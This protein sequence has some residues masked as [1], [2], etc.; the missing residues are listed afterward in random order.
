MAADPLDVLVVDD[1]PGDVALIEQ[2]IAEA[3]TPTTFEAVRDGQQALNRIHQRGDF[4]STDHPDLILLD[5]NLPGTNGETVLKEIREHPSLRH[6]PVMVL[7][8]SRNEQ[9]VKQSYRLGANGYFPKPVDPDE[10]QHM[11]ESIIDLCGNYAW[12]PPVDP[13]E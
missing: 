3:P 12:L 4:E 9:T 8:G 5:W 7:S 11:V 10:Y 13:S 2:A 6:V 1:N